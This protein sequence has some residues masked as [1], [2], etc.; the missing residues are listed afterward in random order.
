MNNLNKTVRDIAITLAPLI[1]GV[2]TALLKGIDSHSI[3][4]WLVA[5]GGVGGFVTA[6][7]HFVT[8]ASTPAP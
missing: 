6:F 8:S 7:L 5:S 2:S 1:I 4:W 3:D